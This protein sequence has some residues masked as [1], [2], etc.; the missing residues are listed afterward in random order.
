M[1]WELHTHLQNAQWR[2]FKTIHI[3]TI[4]N[5]SMHI[6]SVLDQQGRSNKIETWP[7]LFSDTGT[8]RSSPRLTSIVHN[9]LVKRSAI[10]PLIA[11]DDGI[12]KTTHTDTHTHNHTRRRMGNL[13]IE[14]CQTDRRQSPAGQSRSSRRHTFTHKCTHTNIPIFT[15]NVWAY[16]W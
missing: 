8:D 11:H 9:I 13:Y 2:D 14:S 15:W 10:V 3:Y 16:G 5:A 4:D 7:I 1:V 12:G 6:F